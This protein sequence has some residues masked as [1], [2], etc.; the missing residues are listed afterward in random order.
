MSCLRSHVH[1]LTKSQQNDTS[2][3]PT[4]DPSQATSSV[5]H[6]STNQEGDGESSGGGG[7]VPWPAH[8]EGCGGPST[9]VGG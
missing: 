9:D 3:R 6:L 8:N 2:L 1:S 5:V 7:L 4:P